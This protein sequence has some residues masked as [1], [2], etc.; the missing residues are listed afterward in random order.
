MDTFAKS[1]LDFGAV[2]DGKTD[3]TDAFANALSGGNKKISI[4]FGIYRITSTLFVESNTELVFSDGARIVAETGNEPC[5]SN[6]RGA[7]GMQIHSLS[8]DGTLCETEIFY[9]IEACDIALCGI[10]FVNCA[11]CAIKLEKT[12][13]FLI[14]DVHF[15]YFGDFPDSCGVEILRGCEKGIVSE[16]NVINEKAVFGTLIRICA[17]KNADEGV[18]DIALFEL[19]AMN[20]MGFV[21]VF[22]DGADVTN[23]RTESVCGGTRSAVSIIGQNQAVFSE[24]SFSHLELFSEDCEKALVDIKAST[25]KLSFSALSRPGVIDNRTRGRGLAPTLLFCA[26]QNMRYCIENID[27]AAIQ[28]IND[29]SSLSSRGINPRGYDRADFEGVAESGDRLIIPDGGYENI[30]FNFTEK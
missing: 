8:V 25:D 27:Y 28:K 14:S 16:I 4:P 22:S 11:P 19:S 10:N 30:T 20:C 13:G 29:A 17:G 9:F 6:K 23:I 3:D 18:R 12:K 2:G 15:S 21:S 24:L 5:F 1:I 7:C 26:E